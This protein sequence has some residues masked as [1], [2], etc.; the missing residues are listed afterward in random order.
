MIIIYK[1]TF[2]R[3][4]ELSMIKIGLLKNNQNKRFSWGDQNL[5]RVGKEVSFNLN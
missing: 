5:M 2:C 4:R 1:C 3:T